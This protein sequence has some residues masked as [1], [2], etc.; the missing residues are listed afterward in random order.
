MWGG[1]SP[2]SPFCNALFPTNFH[3]ADA[4][5]A[6]R[7]DPNASGFRKRRNASNGEVRWIVVLLIPPVVYERETNSRLSL[8]AAESE[9][10]FLLPLTGER[11]T[12]EMHQDDRID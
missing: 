8:S 4:G 2:R 7:S 12:M 6:P 3:K 10:F 9:D 1:E 11:E 5:F